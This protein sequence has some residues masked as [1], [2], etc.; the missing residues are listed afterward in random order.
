MNCIVRFCGAPPASG[1]F[2][3]ISESECHLG[4]GMIEAAP[5]SARHVAARR[6]LRAQILLRVKV[7]GTALG[8]L[9]VLVVLGLILAL[10]GDQSGVAAVGGIAG[11]V[12][13]ILIVALVAVIAAL[14]QAVLLLLSAEETAKL[15]PTRFQRPADAGG[16]SVGE[17]G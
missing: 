14:S 13:V 16:A 17:T 15:E 5:E 10:T 9:I 1:K 7:G 11:I 8:L 2:L 4:P 3:S 6:A 12:G